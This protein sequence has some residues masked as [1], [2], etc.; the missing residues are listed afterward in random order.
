MQDDPSQESGGLTPIRPPTLSRITG[1]LRPVERRLSSTGMQPSERG[2]VATPTNPKV[3]A[4]V[5]LFDL[6]EET[7]RCLSVS[8]AS[9]LAIQ[10]NSKFGSHGYEGVLLGPFK[11]RPGMGVADMKR[12]LYALEQSIERSTQAQ[13]AQIVARMAVRTKMRVQGEGEAGL[14]AETMVDDLRHYPADVVE[15]ACEF[16]V[17]GGAEFKFFP[18]WPELREIC[19]KRMDGRRRLIKALAYYIAE[20]EPERVGL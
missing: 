8:L 19:E 6:P 18:S 1:H 10:T 16:W 17:R 2:A 4:A 13:V 20:A 3:A 11:I 9:H 5:A 15:F 12:D 14:L 7:T